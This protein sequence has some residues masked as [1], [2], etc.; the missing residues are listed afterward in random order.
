MIW[1]LGDGL[2]HYSNEDLFKLNPLSIAYIGDCIYELYL[3]NLIVKKFGSINSN[4]LHFEVI[5][6]VNAASQKNAYFKVKDI[7]TEEEVFYFKKGR[8][9]KV[10][11]VP[12]NF[13]ISDYKIATGLETL[14][15]Y[16]YITKN[17][18]RLDKILN[19]IIKDINL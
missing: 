2:S 3:R 10:K 18:Q 17:F 15:G 13:S 1:S 16:L 7:L 19:E 5:K 11:T 4:K 12:K 6:Y 14:V 9:S 8:N